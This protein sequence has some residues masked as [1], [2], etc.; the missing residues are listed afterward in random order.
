METPQTLIDIHKT[1]YG[2][3]EESKNTQCGCFT[4]L[5]VF[6]GNEITKTTEEMHG[7]LSALCP[8]CN[9]D[10]VIPNVT[11][12]LILKELNHYFLSPIIKH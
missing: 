6:N 5:H 11:D 1:C 4:C 12:I 10:T 7:D 3:Y 2:S 9:S 8:N